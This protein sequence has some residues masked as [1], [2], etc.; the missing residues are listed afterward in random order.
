MDLQL[1]GCICY[2]WC[3]TCCLLCRTSL[4]HLLVSLRSLNVL[5]LTHL[6]CSWTIL[7]LPLITL[8]LPFYA[9]LLVLGW[10]VLINSSFLYY[11]YI[12]VKIFLSIVII[13]FIQDLVPTGLLS[14]GSQITNHPNQYTFLLMKGF[15]DQRPSVLSHEDVLNQKS[16][17]SHWLYPWNSINS[18]DSF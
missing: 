9:V 5:S 15:P 7:D 10:I 17:S 1:I 8:S 12:Y 13:L 11:Y 4:T 2:L 18:I 14:I 16:R 3:L 6:D